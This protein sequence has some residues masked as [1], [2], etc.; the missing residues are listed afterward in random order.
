MFIVLLLVVLGSTQIAPEQVEAQ[1]R[2]AT[3]NVP[4]TILFVDCPGLVSETEI[5]RFAYVQ[6]NGEVMVREATV[7]NGGLVVIEGIPSVVFEQLS[8]NWW[9]Q[10]S[11]YR[12]ILLSGDYG[13]ILVEA[14]NWYRDEQSGIIYQVLGC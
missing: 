10:D 9:D 14:G 12:F 3:V 11:A 7:D 4:A 8:M 13:D 5:V 6:L 1:G 2:G